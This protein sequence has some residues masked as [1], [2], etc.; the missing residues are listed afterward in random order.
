MFIFASWRRW[1]LPERDENDTPFTQLIID[2]WSSWARTRN[3]NPDPAYLQARGYVNT[4]RE[5]QSAGL[6]QPVTA[7]S[8]TLRW[9]QWPSEQVPFGHSAQCA[10]LG[11]PLDYFFLPGV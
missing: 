1:G 7:E 6:W 5:L 9:L 4:T 2:S 8:Q 11:Q 3:P 10:A